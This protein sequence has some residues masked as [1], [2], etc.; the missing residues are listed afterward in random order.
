MGGQV[1]LGQDYF[2][3]LRERASGNKADRKLTFKVKHSVFIKFSLKVL[4]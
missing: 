1:A 3:S 2:W 4:Y